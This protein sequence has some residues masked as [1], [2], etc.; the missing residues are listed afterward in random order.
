[1]SYRIVNGRAYPVGNIG[2]VQVNKPI[3]NSKSSGNSFKDVL[4]KT[5][6]NNGYTVSKHAA[7]R[8]ERINFSEMDM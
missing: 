7:D 4:N 8:L 5:I 1:M 6:E 2:G 3:N